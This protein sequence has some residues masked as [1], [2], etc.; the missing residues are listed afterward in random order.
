HNRTAH[1]VVVGHDM[2]LGERGAVLADR[3]GEMHPDE[4]V[5][6]LRIARH[7]AEARFGMPLA[8]I[9]GYGPR[10]PEHPA[11]DLER[12][13]AAGGIER[14]IVPRAK[15]PVER[16]DD[17]VEG[18]AEFVQQP[19][20]AHGARLVAVVKADHASSSS[21]TR[22]APASTCAPGSTSTS[23][24]TPSRAAVSV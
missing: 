23:A 18:N 7:P 14:E 9:L 24:T 8:E 12:G 16:M 17:H 13:D 21:R 3:L 10:L 6:T 5:A 15:R 20:R 19:E 11:V 22:A 2:L 1:R 4:P